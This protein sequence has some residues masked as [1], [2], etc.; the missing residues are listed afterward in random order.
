V[1]KE[2]GQLDAWLQQTPSL[3]QYP[4]S[5]W[6]EMQSLGSSHTVPSTWS[7]TQVL[8]PGPTGGSQ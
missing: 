8:A 5:Q 4:L 3:Q 7:A 2:S 6:P 1:E